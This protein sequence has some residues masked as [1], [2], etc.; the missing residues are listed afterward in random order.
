MPQPLDYDS[1]SRA[2]WHKVPPRVWRAGAV[3]A[4]LGMAWS[5]AAVGLMGGGFEGAYQ[6]VWLGAGAVAGIAAGAHTV[7]S[8]SRRRGRESLVDVL[9]TF[10]LG[11]VAYWAA[12]V[13]LDRCG[14]PLDLGGGDRFD[15]SETLTLLLMWLWY[16]T[17][18]LGLVLIPLCFA[19]RHA[20]WR[21]YDCPTAA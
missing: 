13:L 10:Y 5:V 20:V 1:R 21:T 6:P 14:L 8:R 7:Q 3:S 15:R 18:P 4:A 12:F 2:W 9:V 19:S 16:G 17:F 11:I